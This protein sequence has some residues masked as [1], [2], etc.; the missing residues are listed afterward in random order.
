MTKRRSQWDPPWF[1]L[2][3][4]R[5]VPSPATLRA[6]AL[7]GAPMCACGCARR[8]LPLAQLYGNTYFS[9]ACREKHLGIEG[10]KRAAGGLGRP[11]A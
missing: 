2:P 4:T 5:K 10:G 9:R 1:S 3:K 11:A 8:I 7:P 6:V